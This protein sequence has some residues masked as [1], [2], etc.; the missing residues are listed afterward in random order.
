MVDD[1]V[2]VDAWGVAVVGRYPQ[3]R[4]GHVVLLAVYA[5]QPLGVA[6]GLGVVVDRV[7]FD[8][9]VDVRTRRAA[10][11][12][13]RGGKD[14]VVDSQLPGGETVEH[15]DAVNLVPGL[16]RGTGQLSM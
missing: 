5:E 13:T 1:E 7:G 10:V 3:G 9:L 6:L 12:V 4:P 2:E 14:H 16:Q 8:R 11:D 15:D